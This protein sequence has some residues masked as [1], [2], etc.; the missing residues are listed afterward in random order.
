MDNHPDPAFAAMQRKLLRT[1]RALAELEE[2]AESRTRE[3]YERNRTLHELGQRMALFMP[4]QVRLLIENSQSGESG[5]SP[6]VARRTFITVLFGDLTGF[7]DITEVLDPELVTWMINDY[8]DMI[9]DLAAKHHGLLDKFIGDGF[10]VFW[11]APE[12]GGR[13][14]DAQMAAEFAV[15]TQQA[16]QQMRSDWRNQG[17][18]HLVQLRIG[19]HSGFCSVGNFGSKNRLQF[20]AIG[21]PVNIAARLEKAALPDTIL[22]SHETQSLIKPVLGCRETGKIEVKGIKHPITT[23]QVMPRQALA[24]QSADDEVTTFLK[25]AEVLKEIN[26]E[27]LDKL[28]RLAGQR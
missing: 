8:S 21:S 1:Q 26:R 12:T 7:T 4:P 11:G 17:L 25:R 28:H 23:Y 22:T 24:T 14:E 18:D 2:I 19:L 3:L 6:L 5:Q 27:T 10:M 15:E 9:L 13:V 20:T 16:F